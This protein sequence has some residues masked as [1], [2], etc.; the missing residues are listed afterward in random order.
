LAIALASVGG[1]ISLA[2]GLAIYLAGK[3]HSGMAETFKSAVDRCQTVVAEVYDQQAKE[4]QRAHAREQELL[5][6]IMQL[7][8]D[9]RLSLMPAGMDPD[10]WVLTQLESVRNLLHCSQEE[11]VSILMR[12]MGRPHGRDAEHA[13]SD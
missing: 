7:D 2:A 13:D 10:E 5:L 9:K 6:Q 8:L 3:S 12:G 11:A 1:V 4:R